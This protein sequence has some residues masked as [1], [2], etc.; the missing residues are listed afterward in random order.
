MRTDKDKI[1]DIFSSKLGSF[2][3]ELPPLMWEKID[4]GLSAQDAKPSLTVKAGKSNRYKIVTWASGAAAVALL[5]LFLLPKYDQKEGIA[6]TD[7]SE[8]YIQAGK[9]DMSALRARVVNKKPDADLKEQ[10]PKGHNHISFTQS[11]REFLADLA[12]E[13]YPEDNKQEDIPIS[14]L[15]EHNNLAYQ[16][17]QTDNKHVEDYNTSSGEKQ[18]VLIADNNQVQEKEQ[19]IE[20][21]EKEL[22]QKIADFEADAKKGEN[23]LAE[24]ILPNPPDMGKSGDESS[25]KGFQ[26]GAGGSGA[27]SKGKD[28]QVQLRKVSYLNNAMEEDQPGSASASEVASFHRQ[29]MD[30]EH[31]QPISF[32]VAISKNLSDRVSLETGI[33]YTYVTSKFKSVSNPDFNA[34]DNQYFHYLGIPLSVNYK[35]LEWKKLQVYLS[36][37]GEVQKDF[38][39]RINSKQ[40]LKNLYN[41]ED[42]ESRTISQDHPQFS[43]T[44]SL[45]LSYPI[46]N[47]LSVYTK[48]GA[49]YYFD[50]KNPY[51]TIYSDRR[52]IFNLNIGLKFGF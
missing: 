32:G 8:E 15:P 41:A 17:Q 23:L 46:Y 45:G 18:P 34:K 42:T 51:E 44:S 11:T 43:L 27:F 19:P 35:V 14:E 33:N 48:I 4:A 3:P 9:V 28:Q 16:Q 30:M 1:K 6:F 29:K 52:W 13:T 39:G 25:S 26:I 21:F 7:K 12:K 5:L 40:V 20:E 22:A 31:S 47:K 49:A 50:A 24:H 2:E 38:Y 36:A 37:G 10:P